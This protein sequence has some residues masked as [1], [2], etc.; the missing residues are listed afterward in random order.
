MNS[1]EEL[2]EEARRCMGAVRLSLDEALRKRLADRAVELFG[3]ANRVS[4]VEPDMVAMLCELST[5]SR[6][7]AVSATSPL[8]ADELLKIARSYEADAERLEQLT[9]SVD[10]KCISS[11][12]SPFALPTEHEI[13]LSDEQVK[14]ACYA[15][16]P[17]RVNGCS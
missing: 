16:S 11:S 1:V 14:D 12:G 2:L 4:D 7:S 13:T 3:L 6:E 17:H 9:K 5:R 8:I 10:G 15:F